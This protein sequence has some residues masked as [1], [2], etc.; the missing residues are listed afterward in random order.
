[1]AWR[2]T[3]VPHQTP[4]KLRIPES[5]RSFTGTGTG[6]S[7]RKEELQ[8]LECLGPFGWNDWYSPV[9]VEKC[10]GWKIM[11][12][13]K[14]WKIISK[15]EFPMDWEINHSFSWNKGLGCSYVLMLI[16]WKWWS[17]H[18]AYK[19]QADISAWW[20]SLRNWTIERGWDISGFSFL[21]CFGVSFEFIWDIGVI[22]ETWAA[23]EY[24][25][26]GT[27]RVEGDG[28][29]SRSK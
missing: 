22:Q 1:M 11:L 29:F 18:L 7:E 4:W 14:D 6:S 27:A 8:A 15:N 13:F 17:G 12:F 3:C 10:Q 20:R 9:G 23:N 2:S 19:K 26:S 5:P 28:G 21:S 25:P 16:S 24:N